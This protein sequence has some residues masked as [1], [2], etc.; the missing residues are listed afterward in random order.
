MTRPLYG[1]AELGRMFRPRSIAV[2][3]ASEKAGS[4]GGYTAQNLAEFEGEVWIVNP[5]R[6]TVFGQPC[7][8]SLSDLPGV[9]DCVAICTPR[10]TVA[11]LVAEAAQI[12]AGG[13]VLY[14]SGY[15]ETGAEDGAADQA[16]L[17]A[18]ARKHGIPVLGPNCLGYVHHARRVGVTFTPRYLDVPV[19]PGKVGVVSQSGALRDVF[20]QL[21]HRG[22]GFTYLL[23]AGNS[24]D[25]DVWDCVSFLCDDPETEVIALLFEGVADGARFREAGEKARRAGKRVVAYNAAT[26]RN[27]KRAAASHTG[28][29]A[30]DDAVVAAAMRQAG[31]IAVERI[32]DL[33]PTAAFLAKAPV[34]P[35]G[36]GAAVLS[37]SGGACVIA[38]A[39]AEAAGVPLPAPSEAA[40]ARLRAAM[41]DFVH[42]A[43]PCDITAMTLG[44]P[45][46]FGACVDAFVAEPDI[47]AM[48]IAIPAMIPGT[49]ES[50][51][52]GIA[53]LAAARP[54]TAFAV[55]WMVEWGD[56]PAALVAE[57]HP[58]LALFRSMDQAMR[59][60][61]GWLAPQAAPT[62]SLRRNALPR[63]DVPLSE[64]AAKAMLAAE[65]IPVPQET[66]ALS[67]DAAK[68][69]LAQIGGPVA[70]KLATYRIAHKT[71]V[72]GVRL[73]ISDA[74]GMDAAWDQLVAA[75]EAALP[76]LPFEGVLVQQMVDGGIE[77]IV[78]GT[79]DPVFGPV[80]TVG[81]GGIM[82][83]LLRDTA[84]A[85]APVTPEAARAMI[86]GLRMRPLLDGWRGAPA[87]E[88]DALCSLVAQVSQVL[89]AGRDWIAELDINP[90]IARPDGAFAV[91]ALI[92]ARDRAMT[93]TT[94]ETT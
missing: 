50:R 4:F 93:E 65:D 3:G 27:A 2:V 22:M 23:S 74:A 45:A 37:T 92:V 10:A 31:F 41:P 89:A 68:A 63:P 43:N 44:D 70:V 88:I 20:L 32:E 60:L 81:A 47:G 83:E 51:V 73:G 57:R 28:S 14:A 87:A 62:A 67:V 5:R 52:A 58:N 69:A 19:L 54:D 21:P 85:L 16:V 17:A 80:V 42:P 77:M 79:I 71:E 8:A 55:V 86:D 30:G 53:E 78:G 46:M 94:K 26:G 59:A 33:C 34:R 91:D 90:V 64:A 84:T 7:F 40:H 18:L 36:Q 15:A 61:C 38:A 24:C 9:P 48:L 56:A 75:Q 82:A 49:T 72:G 13:V 66:T 11:A 29:L 1:E 35:K 76:G 39:K 12:G 25:V 6:D